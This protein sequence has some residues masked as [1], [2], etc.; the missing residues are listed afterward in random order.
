MKCLLNY[1]SCRFRNFG[2]DITR[3]RELSKNRKDVEVSPLF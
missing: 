2:E 3:E 1:S